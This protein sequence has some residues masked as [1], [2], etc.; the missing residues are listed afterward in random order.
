MTEKK[1]ISKS[2][3]GEV[4]LQGDQMYWSLDGNV[5][6]HIDLSVVAVLGEYTT[7]GGPWLDDWFFVF[8]YSDGTF[9]HVPFYVEGSDLLM[10]YLQKHFSS[11]IGSLVGSTEWKSVVAYPKELE[12][13]TLFELK[14]NENLKTPSNFFTKFLHALGIG[15]YDTDQEIVLLEDVKSYLKTASR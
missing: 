10:S 3:S 13:K 7:A 9:F 12:A 14:P 2:K 11:S 1:G 6:L 5:L 4:K 8:V 15:K